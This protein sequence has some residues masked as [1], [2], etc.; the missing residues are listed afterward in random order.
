M[1]P[2]FFEKKNRDFCFIF[3]YL[4]NLITVQTMHA[5]SLRILNIYAYTKTNQRQQRRSNS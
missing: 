2:D 3:A 1:N 5:S 4:N